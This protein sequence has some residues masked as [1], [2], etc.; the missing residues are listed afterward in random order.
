MIKRYGG[1]HGL[2]DVGLLESAVARPQASFAGEDF[3]PTVFEKAAA[4]MH[5]LLKN[6]P[7]VDGNKRTAYASAGIFLELNGFELANLH[8]AS[9]LFTKK[10]ENTKLTIEQIAA[11]LKKNS[12]ELGRF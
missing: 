7:F 9:F 6:H 11:W 2:R 4:L 3:Y 12:K 1:A 10:V 5:S 8:R